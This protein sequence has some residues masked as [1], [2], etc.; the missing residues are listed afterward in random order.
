MA[1]NDL[2]GVDVPG[3][4]APADLAD[5]ETTGSLV[6]QVEQELGPIT[7]LVNNAA[8]VRLGRIEEVPEEDFW[9]VVDV[10]LSAAFFLAQACAPAMQRLGFGRIVTL[11]S[12]WGQIGW[13][14]AT[15]YCASK[16]GLISLTKALARGLGPSGITANAIAPSVVATSGLAIDAEHAGTSL[17]A[18]HREYI[19]RIPL[20][21][22]GLPC[23]IAA[24]VAFLASNDA[25]SL[26]G[27][28]LSPNGG[29]TI[30]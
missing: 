16:A 19:R 4:A 22:L 8:Y 1:R 5:P 15:A 11:S 25:S 23:E 26:T 2:P 28:V 18:L 30:A 29:S 3:H 9:R 7:L 21:R 14:E 24:L 27:Q 20:G 13:P 12:E 6:A 10:N 17:E